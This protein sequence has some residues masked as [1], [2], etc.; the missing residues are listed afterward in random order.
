MAVSIASPPIQEHRNLTETELTPKDIPI[1]QKLL[2]RVQAAETVV[3]GLCYSPTAQTCFCFEFAVGLVLVIFLIL[4]PPI[5]SAM[6]R[7]QGMVS[8]SEVDFSIGKSI[9]GGG[10]AEE[11][12]SAP[13]LV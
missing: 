11:L 12:G 1:G 2:L 13:W 8:E 10:L 6:A 9:I 4:V 5:L 3:P 7:F